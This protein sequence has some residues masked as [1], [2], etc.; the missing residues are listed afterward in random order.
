[1]IDTQSKDFKYLSFLSSV[2]IENTTSARCKMSAMLVHKGVPV[3]LGKNQLKSHP[4]QAKFSMNEHSIFLHAEIDAIAKALKQ[5]NHKELSECTLYVCRVLKDGTR[6]IAKPCPGC[7]RAI[8]HFGIKYVAWT[9]SKGYKTS[10]EESLNEDINI[11][12][13]RK[14]ANARKNQVIYIPKYQHACNS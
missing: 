3:A 13:A 6:A 1:M 7:Q 8:K 4:L 10:E 2:A 12:E 14:A 5:L 9:T 11:Y